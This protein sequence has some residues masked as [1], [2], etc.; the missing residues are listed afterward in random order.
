MLFNANQHE[1]AILRV[2]ELASVCPEVDTVACRIVE[3]SIMHLAQV[4]ISTLNFVMIRR[5]YVSNLEYVPRMTHV[6]M[7]L[8]TISLPLST[9]SLSHLSQLDIL[10][11]RSLS[12]YVDSRS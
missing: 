8:L 3:V 11:T 5:I 1:H 10:N 12:W 4:H 7:M 2:Q 9:S 6:T